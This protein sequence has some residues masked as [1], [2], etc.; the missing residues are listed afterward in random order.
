MFNF[1]FKLSEKRMLFLSKLGLFTPFQVLNYFPRRYEEF[2]PTPEITKDFDQKRVVIRGVVTDKERL[3]RIRR[4]LS[5]FSFE[6]KANDD[7]YKV[8]VFNRDFFYQHISLDKAILVAGKYNHLKKEI[9]ATD[10]FVKDLDKIGIR[11]IYSLVQGVTDY[12]FKTVVDKAMEQVLRQ[13]LLGEIIPPSLKAKY[14]LVD[15]VDAYRFAHQPLTSE[16]LT[17]SY[18]YL[19]YEE[20]L[21]YALGVQKLKRFNSL[22]KVSGPKKVDFKLIENLKKNLP[23]DLTSTQQ[24]AIDE[25]ISDLSGNTTM[26][27][28]LQGDV[29]S[30]KTVVAMLGLVANASAGFQGVFMAPTDILS[31]QHYA[32]FLDY[33]KSF[34]IKIELLVSNLETTKK[35]EVISNIAS[36]K[37]DIVIGTHALIQEAVNF[38]KLGLAVIDEQHRFGVNQRKTLREKGAEVELL[39][40][41]ATPIPRTLA[42]SIYGDM[43]VSTLAL[44]DFQKR[45]ITTRVVEDNDIS[46]VLPKLDA[47]LAAKEKAFVIASLIAGENKSF[48]TAVKLYDQFKAKYQNVFLLHGK[49]KEEEKI[50]VM[51]QFKNTSA[52]ILVSTT[53]VEVGIDIKEASMMIIY[54]AN[55]FGL[56]QLHQLRGRVGRKGQIGYCY[57]LTADSS[58]EALKRLKFLEQE[59]DGFEIARFDLNL[60]GPGDIRGYAQSGQ[61]SFNT[62]NIFDD[63]KI[64]EVARNDAIMI[65]ANPNQSEYHAILKFSDDELA[66]DIAVID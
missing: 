30:G 24:K 31:R 34:N 65:L 41:S 1:D 2:F 47:I 53:V 32:N 49:M 17:Q 48:Q 13:N 39:L 21:V 60:R 64:F 36:G 25:I 16:A 38:K 43:D 15:R 62:C 59:D 23:F 6:V 20:L 5:R 14:R 4:G 42:I 19:K 27:R 44:A 46:K 58:E 12:E 40:M 52:G 26:Y 29:G 3:I 22:P 35:Q 66:K 54:D 37:V 10:M 51:L 18:R 61:L 9:S 28:L 7:V 57:L 55:R 50:E 33:L 11:P 56:A 63:F 45:Q 8:V